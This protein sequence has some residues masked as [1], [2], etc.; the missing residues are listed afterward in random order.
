MCFLFLW[1]HPYNFYSHC[2]LGVKWDFVWSIMYVQTQSEHY[3][4]AAFIQRN[5]IKAKFKTCSL[6][7]K[8]IVFLMSIK[9]K[10]IY[11]KESESKKQKSFLSQIFFIATNIPPLFQVR[12]TCTEIEGNRIICHNFLLI[13]RNSLISKSNVLF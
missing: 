1:C 7:W 11:L 4:I 2:S 10:R 8:K 6:V 5:L 3:K 13:G 12:N 9:Q